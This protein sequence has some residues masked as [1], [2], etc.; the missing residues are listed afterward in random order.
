[1]K[2][3]LNLAAVIFVM[4]SF[5]I[6][7]LA[8]V[9]SSGSH[10]AVGILLLACGAVAAL[11]APNV[12]DGHRLVHQR[13]AAL[14]RAPGLRPVAVVLWGCAIAILGTLVLIRG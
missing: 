13:F 10:R 7:A 14:P 9:F 8:Y 6:G 11:A 1:M 2:R 3:C 12:V 4:A 5:V